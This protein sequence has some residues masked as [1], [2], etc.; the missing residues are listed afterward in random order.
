VNLTS[1]KISKL[2]ERVKHIPGSPFFARL[3]DHYRSSGNVDKA[4]ALCENGIKHNPGYATGHLLLGRCY[5]EKEHI[6][7]AK[8]EF[9]AVLE[10]DRRN[11]FT[12]KTMGDILAR[13]GEN[14]AAAAF[15]K[16][17]VDYDPLNMEVKNIFNQFEKYY[18]EGAVVLPPQAEPQKAGA[19]QEDAV[20]D[21]T[22]PQPEGPSA[23]VSEAPEKMPE[24]PPSETDQA[25]TVVEPP[26]ETAQAEQVQT[27]K[28]LQDTDDDLVTESESPPEAAPTP[29]EP[30]VETADTPLPEIP[31]EEEVVEVEKAEPAAEAAD[32]AQ[33]PKSE[34][35]VLTEMVDLPPEM[36]GLKEERVGDFQVKKSLYDRLM[37]EEH[38]L[39]ET[40]VDKQIAGDE[41]T[42]EETPEAEAAAELET[43]TTGTEEVEEKE[44]RDDSET[45][46][47]QAD[48]IQET[49]GTKA[50]ETASAEGEKGAPS[51]EHELT[52]D[53]DVDDDL[54]D[55]VKDVVE[56]ESI[57]EIE[58]TL[59]ADVPKGGEAVTVELGS[60]VEIKIPDGAPK[61]AR[62]K[63]KKKKR[64]EKKK[65]A[66]RPKKAARA[67]KRKKD[68]KARKDSKKE[69]PKKGQ[70]KPEMA[71]VEMPD[72]RRVVSNV[73]TVSLAEIYVR[74][75]YKEQAL[76]VYKKLLDKRPDNKTIIEKIKK[77][78]AETGRSH[79]NQ[80]EQDKT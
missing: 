67:P 76:A 36:T 42:T 48:E 41:E 31:A 32:T 54:K 57:K 46:E 61:T 8:K 24:E 22:A 26:S 9:Q 6:E 74:Q 35:G 37:D 50:V 68:S 52:A 65:E 38:E 58:K 49:R 33:S 73:A 40:M 19:A 12:L 56:D 13:N 21:T 23:G 18:E 29:A 27:E 16:R 64:T 17:A 34:T 72:Q 44:K 60:D 5:Y 47:V 53:L 11:I 62:K 59:Q 77:L 43:A 78:E 14:K 4:I 3:A 55:F 20:A 25:A 15:Y 80:K 63:G 51:L 2:E 45:L 28:A 66:A 39:I 7:E 79:G 1:E 75:G 70:Q 69:K 30:S 71:D 10:L